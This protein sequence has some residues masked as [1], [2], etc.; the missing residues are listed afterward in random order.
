VS[1]AAREPYA[2][3]SGDDLPVYDPGDARV[4][5]ALPEPSLG[6]KR[7]ALVELSEQQAERAEQ[8]V[9]DV[10]DGWMDR[11]RAKV[12]ATLNG[13]RARKGTKWWNPTGD[14]EHKLSPTQVETKTRMLDATYI[15]PDK[16]VAEVG[17][18]IRPVALR[19]AVDAGADAAARLGVLPRDQHGDGM[20]A[21]DHRALEDAVDQAVAVI[22]HTAGTHV[23]QV[24]EAILK[25]DS[26][27]ESLDEVLDLVEAAHRRGGNWVRMSGRTL[28]NALRNEAALRSAQALGVTHMQWLSRRDGDVRPTHVQA[29]GQVRRIDDEFEVGAWRLRFPGDPKDLPASWP[30]VA[31][32]R[33]SPLF[34]TPDERVTKAVQLLNDQVAGGD[35]RTVRRLLAAAASA[36][37]VPVPANAPPA[38]WAAQ[39]TVTEPFVAYRVLDSLIEATAGQWLSFA[40]ALSLGLAAPVVFSSSAP[41]LAVAVP[42]GSVVTVVGGSIVLPEGTA[43]EV[44]GQTPEATLTRLV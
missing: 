34:R 44:V 10:L 18:S 31:G 16:L 2:P 5:E 42:V 41:V 35:P 21:V 32:C 24:R 17:E 8:Q 36:P 11:L 12:E 33:C 38:P 7:S 4:R 6:P 1:S 14:V 28:A 15:A 9:L 40:G 37:E 29:D 20:F 22:L 30:E 25:A 13:P 19:I 39:V 23:T 43:V 26:T 3:L 27:A